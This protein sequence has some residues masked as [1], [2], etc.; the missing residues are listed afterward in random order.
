[1][2]QSIRESNSRYAI[3]LLLMGES[4]DKDVERLFIEWKVLCANYT[5]CMVLM[6]FIETYN[7]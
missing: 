4:L 5:L 3:V 6:C 2:I 1:M 7:Y